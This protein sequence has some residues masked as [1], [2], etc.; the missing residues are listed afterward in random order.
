MV[1]KLNFQAAIKSAA[2]AASLDLQGS[3]QTTGTARLPCKSREAALATD[4]IHWSIWSHDGPSTC[5]PRFCIFFCRWRGQKLKNNG[6]NVWPL[7]R[8]PRREAAIAADLITARKCIPGRALDVTR[9]LILATWDTCSP[10]RREAASGRK[11]FLGTLEEFS[12]PKEFSSG[13]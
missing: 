5:S 13:R 12:R 8:P 4:L 6:R 10:P 1:E 9:S 11:S 3:Q 7:A 2:S